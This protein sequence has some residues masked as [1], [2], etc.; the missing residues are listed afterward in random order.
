[1]P[2]EE[3]AKRPGELVEVESQGDPTPA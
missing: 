3:S 2:C 1:L